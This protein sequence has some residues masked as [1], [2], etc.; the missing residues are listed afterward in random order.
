M[1]APA[2]QSLMTHLKGWRMASPTK[3]TA[4]HMALQA[5]SPSRQSTSQWA[6]ELAAN[7]RSKV[8]TSSILLW[9]IRW[10]HFC[11]I[12]QLG[13]LA[14]SAAKTCCSRQI[15][16]SRV[17]VQCNATSSNNNNSC[18]LLNS[19]NR[20]PSYN[21]KIWCK[22]TKIIIT[23]NNNLALA[24]HHLI[25]IRFHRI[26]TS[27]S[28]SRVL[29]PRKAMASAECLV[30]TVRSMEEVRCSS[31]HL[32]FRS[33]ARLFSR[34]SRLPKKRRSSTNSPCQITFELH[35]GP[36][37]SVLSRSPSCRCKTRS[38]NL[39]A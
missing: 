5:R 36:Q 10:T 32:N 1:V 25:T 35:Q 15:S 21:S 11:T 2:R 27:S 38:I 17:L 20:M 30:L 22:R 24:S 14:Q 31:Y 33:N 23:S 6:V 28:S 29:A 13:R 4:I 3:C 18:N 7:K 16:N 8:W 34:I 9:W 19:S 12:L 39:I 37:I 26:T